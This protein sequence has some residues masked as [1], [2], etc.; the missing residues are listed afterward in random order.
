[1]DSVY[2]TQKYVFEYIVCP[3]ILALQCWY[4]KIRQRS[5]G[6]RHNYTHCMEGS[7]RQTYN[8]SATCLTEL[9]SCNE[10]RLLLNTLY[11]VKFIMSE[12]LSTNNLSRRK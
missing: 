4:L 11:F 9:Q 3:R 5:K 1:M 7:S 2:S 10:Y 8:N 6:Q 12:L